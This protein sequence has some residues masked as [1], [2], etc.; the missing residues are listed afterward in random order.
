MVTKIITET[1][2]KKL[3]SETFS[4]IMAIMETV[5][6]LIKH[7]QAPAYGKNTTHIMCSALYTHAVEEYGKLLYLQPLLPNNGFVEIDYDAKFKNHRF[8]FPLALS[9]LPESCKVLNDGPFSSDAFDSAIFDTGTISDWNTRLTIFNT[10]FDENGNV[11]PY[12]TIDLK[13]LQQAVFDFRTE[14]YGVKLP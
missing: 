13:K 6:V 9:K 1:Q 5:D 2:W 8:K 14:M 12:P 7:T 11:K 4:T 10:D 3:Q